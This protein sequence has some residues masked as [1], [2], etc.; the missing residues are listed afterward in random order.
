MTKIVIIEDDD[1]IS[2]MYKMKFELS[3]FQVQVAD[4][5]IQGFEL[6]KN[7]KPDLIMMDFQMPEMDG[8]ATL[9]KIRN[10]KWGTKIPVLFLTNTGKEESPKDLD[11]LNIIDYIVK[12]EMTPKQVVEKVKSVLND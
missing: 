7:F 6:V 3:G 8:V 9:K 4:N 11:N 10:E 1:V 12:A 2:Q 5:G